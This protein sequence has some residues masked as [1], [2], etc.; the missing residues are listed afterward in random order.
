MKI[1]K[2]NLSEIQLRWKNIH[3]NPAYYFLFKKNKKTFV[4]ILIIYLFGC[5]ES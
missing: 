5:A 4:F 2:G 1:P 3:L